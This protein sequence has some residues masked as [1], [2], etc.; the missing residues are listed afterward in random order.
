MTTNAVR[1]SVRFPIKLAL[2]GRT[3]HGMLNALTNDISANGILFTGPELP[4]IDTQIEFTIEMPA[5]VLGTQDDVYVHCLGRVVRHQEQNGESQAAAI[6][7]EYYL[8]A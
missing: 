4:G 5:A 8:R 1:T 3:P 7:D 2:Q 6:I